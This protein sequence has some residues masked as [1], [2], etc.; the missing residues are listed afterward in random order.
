MKI[1]T[2][3]DK[4]KT[5]KYRTVKLKVGR[6]VVT[7]SYTGDELVKQE[8]SIK[9]GFKTTH[10][11]AY[12]HKDLRFGYYEDTNFLNDL[13]V[14]G[15]YWDTI[16]APTLITDWDEFNGFDHVLC[17]WLGMDG[18]IYRI[19]RATPIPVWRYQDYI[20]GF[21]SKEYKNLPELKRLLESLSFT[22]N[23]HIMK[24]PHYNGGGKAVEFE[25]KYHTKIMDYSYNITQLQ[26]RKIAAKFKKEEE[27]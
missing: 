5:V 15:D 27:E 6:F 1:A 10:K 25:Y 26:V 17:I 16:P 4:T 7:D 24:I 22:R 18:N 8:W 13:D 3:S 19:D 14:F 12:D 23:V 2:I 20:G 21:T 11:N 9:G